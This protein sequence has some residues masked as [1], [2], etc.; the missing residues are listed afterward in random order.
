MLLP[1]ASHS[2]A[3]SLFFPFLAYQF[4]RCKSRV[5][6]LFL[7]I[8]KEPK[9]INAVDPY[10]WPT[11]LF[12]LV[13]YF[14]AIIICTVLTKTHYRY[15]RRETVPYIRVRLMVLFGSLLLGTLYFALRAPFFVAVFL[16]PEITNTSF[17]QILLRLLDV[18]SLARLSWF[19][20]FVP[21]SVYKKIYDI[22][23][24]IDKLLT[25]QQLEALQA[26]IFHLVPFVTPKLNI[27]Y[28]WWQR[29]HSLDLLNYR[30]LVCI[31]D[32]KESLKDYVATTPSVSAKQ[33][34]L[35]LVLGTIADDRNY[36]A[37]VRSYRQISRKYRK[38]LK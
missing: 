29:L 7:A 34:Q 18:L 16:N 10:N 21:N 6:F 26:Q 5:S 31:L 32:G 38:W 3:K 19:F 33:R 37:L 15:Q 11:L 1:Q 9:G 28:S 27:N 17:V 36:D 13:T 4:L 12:R 24:F 35:Y 22:F 2:P 14:F 20:F 8:L 25:L 23:V 30:A